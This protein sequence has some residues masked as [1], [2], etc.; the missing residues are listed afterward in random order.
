[1]ADS[2]RGDFGARGA[3]VT[4]GGQWVRYSLQIAS[5]VILA[6]I[7]DPTA[8]GLMAVVTG[9]VTISST[10]GDFGL[11]LS[12]LRSRDLS[13]PQ[14][15]NLLWVNIGLGALLCLCMNTLAA[16]IASFY[17]QPAMATLCHAI[18]PLFIL[19][20]LGAQHRISLNRDGRFGTLALADIVGGLIALLAAVWVGL[21]GLGVMALVVQQ[22]TVALVGLVIVVASQ[23]WLPA[24]PRR[25][26]GTRAL[27][28]FGGTLFLTYIVNSIASSV[29]SMALGRYQPMHIVGAYN[30]AFQVARQPVIQIMSPLTRLSVPRAVRAGHEPN[31]QIQALSSLHNAVALLTSAALSFMVAAGGTL[32]RLLLG[33]QWGG[34]G[35][36]IELLACAGILQTAHQITYWVLLA[37]GNAKVLFLS[38]ITPR[39]VFVVSIL[40]C[41]RFGVL[42]VCLC[43]ILQQALLLV[44]GCGWALPRLGVRPRASCSYALRPVLPLLAISVAV[45]LSK[46]TVRRLGV[47][48]TLSADCVAICVWFACLLVVVVAFPRTRDEWLTQLR[49]LLGRGPGFRNRR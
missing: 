8:F 33:N 48:S 24:L 26:V 36:I 46:G 20:G 41:A 27:L 42:L 14:R 40:I 11:S 21:A 38:E 34:L 30:R 15:S 17:S 28:S 35:P 44:L 39:V 4:L 19:S 1:M 12:A 37:S 47:P 7:L 13:H 16:P 32:G 31:A 22:L 49:S 10:L 23:P 25:N 43:V 9:I 5:V 18:S 3:A 6:R 2:F 45:L 29:D